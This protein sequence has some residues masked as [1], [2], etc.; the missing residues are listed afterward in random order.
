MRRAFITI[1]RWN[2]KK[3]AQCPHEH[4]CL[5]D[6]DADAVFG[7]IASLPGSGSPRSGSLLGKP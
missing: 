5:R 7:Q 4:R 3:L 6:M 1:L 2:L